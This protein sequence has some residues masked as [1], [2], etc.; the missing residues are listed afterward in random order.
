M[1]GADQSRH[2]AGVQARGSGDEHS[3][4]RQILRRSAAG[5]TAMGHTNHADIPVSG[6]MKGTHMRSATIM[7][8][9]AG[10]LGAAATC[11][12]SAGNATEAAAGRYIPG[13]TA[14]PGMGIVPP[15]SGVGYWAISNAYYH[16]KASG[17]IP[18]GN[19]TVALDLKADMW[20]TALAGVYVPELHL[21]GNWTYAVQGAV[22]I[23]WSQAE[24][25]LGPIEADDH[26]AGLGD[27]AVAPLVFG[28]HND[29]MNTFVS[30][31]L[32]VT[33]PTGLWDKGRLVFLGL[34]YWT[35]TPA[36]GFTRLFPEQGLDFSAKFGV[37]INT[38]N[39]DTDYYSGAMAH[40]DLALTKNIT[41]NFS[42]G[43]IAG[44][45]YQF[46]DDDSTF[47][48]AH[49]GFKGRSIAIGPLVSYKAEF[50]KTEVNLTLRWA[51]ELEVKNRMK[52]DAVVFDI[53]GKF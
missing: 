3:G 24:A 51:H 21:P 9:M 41:K 35:F 49:D 32:T 46:Q 45:L 11:F 44:F 18:F 8:L 2:F 22:P 19:D 20:I 36:V 53:S 17:E 7:R 23:A 29:A 42:V 16:G 31:S 43:A 30:T 34:N 39:E 47:A 50:G 1:D 12:S 28:W 40:L 10:C 4:R 52:G 33:A 38:R 37:D 5:G 14:G 15:T 6:K 48:D 25:S 26:L 13:I 27:I